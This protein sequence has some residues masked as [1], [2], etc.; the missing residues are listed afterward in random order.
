MGHLSRMVLMVAVGSCLAVVDPKMR[1]YP[2]AGESI[3][4]LDGD[5]QVTSNEGDKITGTVPGDILTDL[6]ASG[7]I[8]DPLHENNFLDNAQW[9]N[10]TWT[11]SKVFTADASTVQEGVM[12]VFEG[13]KMSA[14][15]SVNGKK[16]GQALDQFLRYEFVIDNVKVG[17]NTI[18]VKFDG[19]ELDGRWMACTGGWDWAPYTQTFNQGA[20]T[21]SYGIW[22]S[23]Y[24]VAM[25]PAVLTHVTPQTYYLG[26]YPVEPLTDGNHGGFKV[27]VRIFTYCKA[28]MTA[29]IDLQGS[30][31]SATQT[32]SFDLPKG[33][34]THTLNMTVSASDI[35]L[36]WPSNMGDQNLYTVTTTLQSGST[37]RVAQRRV[38]FRFFALVTGNDTNPVYVNESK[39]ADGTQDLGM[40]VRVNGA[41]M[42]NRGANMIPMEELEGR[43]TSEMYIQLVKN[44]VEANMNTFRIWGG[45]IFYP[46]VFYD[47]ADELGIVMYH[48][49]MYAQQ[50]H[51]P[52]VTA[53]QDA[54]LRHQIRR[55]SSHPSIMMWDGCNE[56]HVV[57]GTS[58][59]IYATFVM[60]VVVEE[61]KSRIIWPSCPAAGWKSGVHRLTSMPNGS[62][63]GLNPSF[64]DNSV[65]DDTVG[66]G[67]NIETHGPYQHS[68]LW[69]T[70]NEGGFD[71]KSIT[72]PP[73]VVVSKTGPGEANVFASEFGSVV[74]SSFESMSP[75]L[76][77]EHWSIHGGEAAGS[78]NSG[79]HVCNGT[80]PMQQRNYACDDILMKHF[81]WNHANRQ[82]L[83]RTGENSF[84]KQLY[85]CQ[86]GQALEMKA[87]IEQRRSTNQFGIIVWQLNEIWPTG[88][89][90]SIE[91]GTPTV[92]GQVVGGRWKPLQYIYKRTLYQDL[93]AVC[94][95]K[96]M[97]YVKND[98]MTHFNGFVTVVSVGLST[99]SESVLT[100]MTV[101]LQPFAGIKYFN[102]SSPSSSSNLLYITVS[103]SDN[104]VVSSNISPLDYIYNWDKMPTPSITFKISAEKSDGTF[105]ITLTSD[106]VAF[107][108]NLVT[109]AHGRFS[110]NVFLLKG[111]NTITFH[112]FRPQQGDALKSTLRVEDLGTYLNNNN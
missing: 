45:G 97:C 91:Y 64:L 99:G 87:N 84:K 69:P 110:D 37:K 57:I 102:I 103:N 24:V 50:G 74:M 108:V 6:E 28:A 85:L 47:T 80:N 3:S 89:W 111:T 11:Y 93:I 88:G 90:G 82:V 38:G 41:P 46:K 58:T 1:D 53:T 92:K 66:W 71:N 75:S 12:L 104:T 67:S 59:G 40:L 42:F 30:W 98:G 48:D 15:I 105:D 100:N 72:T 19:G 73:I 96:G 78:C 25:G 23:V 62:P 33:N 79:H 77:S 60:T 32:G 107:F 16:V 7:K 43:A 63:L 68:T 2:M 94:G 86:L 29:K 39:N 83:N 76:S 17:D 5:W 44:S 8:S 13:I 18:E 22:K 101:S 4:Y 9:T 10:K 51:S 61:D 27:S 95:A 20:L 14:S 34:S 81:G 31:G 36:W 26:D 35:K 56:C 49:M 106:K 55:L 109:A 112:P 52:K 21:F 65:R 70:V 54:E